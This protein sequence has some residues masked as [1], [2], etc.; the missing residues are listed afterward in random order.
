MCPTRAN[1]PN[2]SPDND[3]ICVTICI[4]ATPCS[5]CDGGNSAV[6]HFPDSGDL[7]VK[8]HLQA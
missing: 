1:V 7:D 3:A 4:N 2:Y 8:G 6:S 5:G